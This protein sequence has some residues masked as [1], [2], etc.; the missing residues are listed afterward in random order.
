MDFQKAPP[1]HNSMNCCTAWHLWRQGL[2]LA[3]YNRAGTLTNGG[4]TEFFPN[5]KTLS[6]YFGSNYESTRRARLVLI[7][8][9]WL[10]HGTDERHFN[11]I[12]HDTWAFTTNWEKCVEQDL[13][14][15]HGEADPF[16]GR[17]FA[18]AG[19]RFRAK[20][21]WILGV[22]KYGYSDDEILELFRKELEAAAC[23]RAKGEHSM[24]G[25]HQCFYRVSQH[26]RE[27]S[28]RQSLG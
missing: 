5:I 6:K 23:K 27:H 17:V 24:T 10:T 15:W 16:I 12:A 25:N 26:L 28:R 13:N 3:I 2:A 22:R 18:I 9:G 19:G 20:P 14:P 8:N 11:F 21:H 4:K 1:K 7:N